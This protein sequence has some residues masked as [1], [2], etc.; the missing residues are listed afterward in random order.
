[1]ASGDRVL[2][3][4]MFVDIVDSTATLARVGDAKWRDLLGE[5]NAAVQLELDRHRGKEVDRAGDGVLAMFDGPAGAVECAAAIG[6]RAHASGLEVRAGVHT[7]EVELVTGGVRGIAVPSPAASPHWLK[8]AS[9]SCP[10]RPASWWRDR[11][12]AS[13]RAGGTS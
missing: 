10:P 4:P 3:T 1:M 6:R 9:F 11:A 13:P 2:A 12:W 7:G 8:G 5:H